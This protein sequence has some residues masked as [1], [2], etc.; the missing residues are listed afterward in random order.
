M[1][2]IVFLCLSLGSTTVKPHDSLG[3]RSACACSEASFGSQNGDRAWWLYY[4]IAAL[5]C[6]FF[7]RGAKGL[8]A[9]DNHKEMFPVQNGKCWSHK[10]F[11]NWVEK[12][13]QGRSKVADDETDVRKWLRQ[14]SK[15]LICYGF[16]RTGKA[17]EQVYQCWWRYVKN[18]FSFPRLEY[19][20]F[21]IH[22]W[23]IYWLCL[24]QVPI[25][26]PPL[27]Q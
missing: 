10:A 3:S 7:L 26:V 25:Y 24:I 1:D 15:D 8:S 13:S 6:T 27:F 5:C 9:K 21:Y 12:F 2:V 4:R 22:L 11:S 14:G 19:H 18:Y 16:R 23:P 17:M 20:M